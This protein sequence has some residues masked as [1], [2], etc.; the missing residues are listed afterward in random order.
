MLKANEQ[1]TYC[2]NGPLTSREGCLCSHV[3]G[4]VAGDPDLVWP[5]C[6]IVFTGIK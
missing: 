3:F 2:Q 6:I 4:T 1:E 5:Y